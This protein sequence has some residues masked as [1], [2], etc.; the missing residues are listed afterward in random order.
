MDPE[1]QRRRHEYGRMDEPS[2]EGAQVHVAIG[3]L[4]SLVK[5][6]MKPEQQLPDGSK[7]LRLSDRLTNKMRHM[8]K[9]W[10]KDWRKKEIQLKKVKRR[11]LVKNQ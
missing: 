2:E 6:E 11:D 8:E 5:G 1:V 7:C 9:N 3:E 4:S 10:K